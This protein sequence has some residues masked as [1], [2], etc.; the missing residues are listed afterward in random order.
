[1]TN[2]K[3]Y[4]V[5]GEYNTY[6]IAGELNGDGNY[7]GGGQPMLLLP[8]QEYKDVQKMLD[9]GISKAEKMLKELD[10]VEMMLKMVTSFNV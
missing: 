9:K 8:L 10:K 5:I 7:I 3:V 6:Q 4:K 1:M 2:S